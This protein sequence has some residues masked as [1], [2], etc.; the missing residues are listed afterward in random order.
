[1]GDR[2]I[3]LLR[4]SKK[5]MLPREMHGIYLD[6]AARRFCDAVS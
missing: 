6:F 2:V 3:Y 4:P 5:F 1:M